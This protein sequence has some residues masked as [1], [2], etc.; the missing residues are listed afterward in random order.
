MRKRRVEL[1]LFQKDVAHIL[2][3]K[4]ESI[5]NWE[6]NHN[7]PKIY[8]LPK[9]IEFLGYV[10]FELQNKTLG[11][12]LIVYRKKH[13]LNQRKFA[14]LLCVNKTTIRDWESNKH[15]PSNKLLKRIYNILG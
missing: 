1:N 9:I 7:S 14:D 6:N 12:K 2:G 10:P 15:R 8:L 5:Y 3:V 13:G 11:D 4:K